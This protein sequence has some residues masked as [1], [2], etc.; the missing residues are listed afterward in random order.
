LKVCLRF[1]SVTQLLVTNAYHQSRLWGRMALL[2]AHIW[3]FH[4][5]RAQWLRNLDLVHGTDGIWKCPYCE[6]EFCERVDVLRH[7]EQRE[8]E[9]EDVYTLGKTR[10]G[11]YSKEWTTP[12]HN[13][14]TP[15]RPLEA[16]VVG[17]TL[18]QR[19]GVDYDLD[20]ELHA[21]LTHPTDAS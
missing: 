3:A 19:L 20:L 6:D 5:C 12:E 10:D 2:E 18:A 9:P 7:C 21:P 11:F 4:S 14:V 1:T 17:R 8:W 13:Y 15:P 16:A